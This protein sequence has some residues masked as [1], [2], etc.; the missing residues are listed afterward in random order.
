MTIKSIFDEISSEPGTNRK[1]EVLKKHKDGPLGTL[2]GKVL[3]YALSKR[4]KFYIKR[5]PQTT[6]NTGTV[7]LEDALQHLAPL[8]LR[9]VT[10]NDAF[11]HLLALLTSLSKDDAFIVERIID[12]DVKLGMGRTNI[13]K[14]YADLIEKTPYM[15]AKPF[16]PEDVKEL[17]EK[18]P[19][20][21]QVKMDGRYANAIIRGGEVD[22]ESRGG[23]PSYL[24]GAKFLEEIS[25]FPD[26]V[27]NGEFTMDGYTR[28]QSNGIIASLINIGGK[29]AEG[30]DATKD[31][32]NLEKDENATREEL[33]NKIKFTVW[34]VITVDEYFTKKSNT[35]YHKRLQKVKDL[36]QFNDNVTM[37]VPIE[38][39]TVTSYEDALAHCVELMQRGEEGSIIKSTIGL[40]KDGKPSWQ[41]KMKLEMDVDM[42]VIGFNYGTKGSKNEKL[43]S[44]LTVSSSDGLVETRPAGMSDK[45]MK[46]VTAN[47]EK[48]MGSIVEVKCCGLSQNDR[49]EYSLLHPV[50]KKFRT[51]E[52]TEADSLKDIKEI[53]KMAKSIK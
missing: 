44:S 53:E 48:L 35:P 51:D 20:F 8:S 13:N 11:S 24:T 34:D 27:L 50:F 17:L 21:S 5:I 25:S 22:L 1:M 47:Q 39:K 16:N 19:C 12:K 41:F 52:K 40:W 30:E 49:G 6:F 38:S 29:L 9:E 33:L 3:Y 7:S 45:D 2:L 18:G 10:G 4:V 46:Y 36:I 42:K 37:V 26:C 31:I 32:A 23:E 15:G 28:Y 14:I 43:I